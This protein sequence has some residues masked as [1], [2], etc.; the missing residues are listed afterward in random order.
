MQKRWVLTPDLGPAGGFP[1]SLWD[2]RDDA[3]VLESRVTKDPGSIKA[4][5]ECIVL[6]VKHMSP[7]PPSSS[8]PSLDLALHP[9]LSLVNHG[10]RSCQPHL[11]LRHPHRVSIRGSEE[12]ESLTEVV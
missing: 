7:P 8:Y 4:S 10:P 11:A 6:T 2:E 12:V 3:Q 1:H 5:W 9:L